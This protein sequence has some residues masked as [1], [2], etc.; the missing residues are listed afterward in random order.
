MIRTP[1]PA[2]REHRSPLRVSS[3]LLEVLNSAFGRLRIHCRY[4]SLRDILIE[5][6]SYEF[7]LRRQ[8]TMIIF[9]YVQVKDMEVLGIESEETH[10]LTA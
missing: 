1:R 4:P 9:L 6:K 7:E 3:T 2:R 8:S 5:G 10:L